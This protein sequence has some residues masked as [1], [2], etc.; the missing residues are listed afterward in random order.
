MTAWIIVGCVVLSLAGLLLCP[1][2]FYLEYQEEFTARVRY[3]FIRVPIYPRP[4]KKKRREKPER[5]EKE[6]RGARQSKLRSLLREKGLQGF[7]DLLREAERVFSGWGRRIL[8]HMKITVFS[9]SVSVAGEDAGRTALE[10]A[11]VCGVVYP[12]AALLLGAMKSREY[13]VSV[14]PD[15]QGKKSRVNFR[16]RL[17]IRLLFAISTNLYTAVQILRT[18]IRRKKESIRQEKAVLTHGG[19]SN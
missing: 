8:S 1:V 12:A 13:Q 4:V 14:V 5:A 15:F 19:S 3:L 6:G 9:L 10:F 17:R 2:T 7:L 16:C 18:M 11:G